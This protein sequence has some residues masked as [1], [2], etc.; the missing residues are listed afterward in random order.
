MFGL[1]YLV[2]VL[3]AAV[4]LLL[5]ILRWRGNPP[6]L[7]FIHRV[8]RDLA[9][10]AVRRRDP[11]ARSDFQ[12][13]VA[14]LLVRRTRSAIPL[15]VCARPTGGDFRRSPCLRRRVH[16]AQSAGGVPT[17]GDRPAKR[18]VDCRLHHLGVGRIRRQ[19]ACGRR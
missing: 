2:V 19:R 4:P 5:T 13:R 15:L 10:I 9:Y 12:D 16:R 18:A 1:S 14:E 11:S 17:R 3:V 8:Y 7:A 6:S